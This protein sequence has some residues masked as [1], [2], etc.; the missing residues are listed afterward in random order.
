MK[1]MDMCV[2][3]NLI[4]QTGC[5][6]QKGHVFDISLF[7]S[8]FWFSIIQ[9]AEDIFSSSSNFISILLLNDVAK[10]IDLIIASLYTYICYHS[11]ELC[12]M[13]RRATARKYA[14]CTRNIRRDSAKN[15]IA[16]NFLYNIVL[17][18]ALHKRKNKQMSIGVSS[19]YVNQR[20]TPL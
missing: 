6:L 17:A 10:S 8:R 11:I 13:A 12:G 7:V 3:I 9:I 2:L 18:R 5:A 15:G 1:I 19:V 20:V 14:H 16:I 4:L